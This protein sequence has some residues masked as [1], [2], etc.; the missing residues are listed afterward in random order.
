MGE[1]DEVRRIDVGGGIYV[2][3]SLPELAA[4]PAGVDGDAPAECAATAANVASGV[5]WAVPRA[6]APAAVVVAGAALARHGAT[7]EG[8]LAAGVLAVLAVLAAIDLRWRV[9][10]NRIVLPATA[11]VLAWQTMLA[12]ARLPEWIGAALGAAAFLALP[13]VIRRG[14]VGMGDVKLGALL[15]V[16]LGA[17]VF[18]ALLLGFLATAPVTLALLLRRRGDVRG[19]TLP[20]GPFLGLGAAVMLLA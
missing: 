11:A 2:R 7:R 8:W 4:A 3:M 20:L 10:P 16:T 19:A 6:A 13:S 9:L 1:Q 12:P 17:E 18:D 15:G 5:K 14:A